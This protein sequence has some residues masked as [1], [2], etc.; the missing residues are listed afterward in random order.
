MT[1]A[2]DGQSEQYD[3]HIQYLAENDNRT[4]KQRR[5]QYEMNQNEMSG[6]FRSRFSPAEGRPI[7][8]IRPHSQDVEDR[9]DMSPFRSMLAGQSLDSF[10]QKA[11]D[12]NKY[13]L[14][15][16]GSERG[17]AI[18]ADEN[19]VGETLL[20]NELGLSSI[21]SR[22]PSGGSTEA[23]GAL[24]VGDRTPTG[25]TVR[26]TTAS[27]LVNITDENIETAIHVG[28]AS[29]TNPLESLGARTWF[30]GD[31]QTIPT[32]VSKYQKYIDMFTQHALEDTKNLQTAKPKIPVKEAFLR[33]VEDI[34]NQL[35]TT[36]ANIK[37]K[38]IET[39]KEPLAPK[40]PA[41]IAA[42][43]GYTEP[44]FRGMHL[45][46]GSDVNPVYNYE[47][48]IHQYSTASPLLA[49]M[50]SSYLSYHPGWTVP[51][52]AFGE[53]ATVSPLLLDTRNYLKVDAEGAHWT[54]VNS[55]AINKAK[56][57]GKHGVEIKNVWDEPNSTHNLGAPKTVYITF[58]EG[59]HTVKS[60]FAERFDKESANML[61]TI[62]AIGIGGAAGYVSIKEE[63]PP[64]EEKTTKKQ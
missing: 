19:T 35:T 8:Y 53:G 54:A 27:P 33:S 42:S 16:S 32:D 59:A 30:K 31:T 11:R 3:D 51:P 48:G 6:D 39:A 37:N 23:T 58:P 46:G 63:E 38:F 5:D 21:P 25:E 2:G 28:L 13:G 62:P 15:M 40:T 36:L 47:K 10:V 1:V 12:L 50:Y 29:N 22:M 34:H 17:S 18:N 41:E 26:F 61:H 44:A 20:G 7:V 49:D 4:E 45:H 43:K 52:N 55:K 64:V 60:K 9:R 56:Q 14:S 57:E 24:K